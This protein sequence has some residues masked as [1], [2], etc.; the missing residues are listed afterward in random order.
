MD[1]IIEFN[2]PGQPVAKGR[3]RF[4]T[5]TGRTYTPEKTTNYENLVRLSYM[6]AYPNQTPYEKNVQLSMTINAYFQIPKATSKKKA[7]QM[8]THIIRPTIKP[9]TDNIAK[10]VCDAL[11]KVAF[12]DDSQI[13]VLKVRKYYGDN[14]SVNIIIHDIKGDIEDENKI[15][16]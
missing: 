7:E 2:V 13:V 12:Y 10:S 14:P 8:R 9:D 6:Q 11:N 4:S 16:H 5:I 3:P 1:D 15:M